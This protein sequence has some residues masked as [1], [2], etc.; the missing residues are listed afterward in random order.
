MKWRVVEAD[1]SAL[2][3]ECESAAEAHALARASAVLLIVERSSDD[4]AI[5]FL[6]G[7]A[8]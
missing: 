7:G 2:V 3:A 4:D 8:A 5:P 6:E 1:T